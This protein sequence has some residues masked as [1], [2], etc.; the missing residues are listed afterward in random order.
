ML[1]TR[2]P[3][4]L[5]TRPREARGWPLRRRLPSAGHGFGARTRERTACWGAGG[6]RSPRLRPS[7]EQS[8]EPA[9]AGGRTRPGKAALRQPGPRHR[10]TS[11]LR[12]R[13]RTRQSALSE[14]PG[15]TSLLPDTR[16]GLLRTLPG[17]RR[18]SVRHSPAAVRTGRSPSARR[19]SPEH[20]RCRTVRTCCRQTKRPWNLSRTRTRAS[21]APASHPV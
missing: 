11:T 2:P 17:I 8:R 9:P 15:G 10:P 7:P 16:Q 4:G 12:P 20:N 21:T 13:A 18:R 14:A 6:H 5:L 19:V 1:G 3:P